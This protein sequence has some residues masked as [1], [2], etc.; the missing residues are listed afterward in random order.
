MTDPKLP[1]EATPSLLQQIEGA[2]KLFLSGRRHREEAA[3]APQ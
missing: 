2:E 3:F 1:T